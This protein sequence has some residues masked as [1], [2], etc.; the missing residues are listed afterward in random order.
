[1]KLGG[2]VLPQNVVLLLHDGE[3]IV[4]HDNGRLET[5]KGTQVE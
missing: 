3:T 2:F 4:F 1:M 5:R